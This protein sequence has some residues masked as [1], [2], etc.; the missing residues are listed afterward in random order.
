MLVPNLNEIM[1]E[2]R[3]DTEETT[4]KPVEKVPE[5]ELQRKSGE[6]EE[7]V[8]EERKRKRGKR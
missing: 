1:V 3:A 8:G 7:E 6:E 4:A 2:I 5:K